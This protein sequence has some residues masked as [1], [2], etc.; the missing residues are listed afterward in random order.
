M[1]KIPYLCFEIY[2]YN[3]K[4]NLFQKLLPSPCESNKKATTSHLF[5]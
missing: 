3:T 1:T 4:V 5:L 2:N